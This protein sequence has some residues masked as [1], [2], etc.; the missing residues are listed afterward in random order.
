MNKYD[1]VALILL[2]FIIAWIIWYPGPIG[3]E[4]NRGK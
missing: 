3:E 4:R 2:P 1:I